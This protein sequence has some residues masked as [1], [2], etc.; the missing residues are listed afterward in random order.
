MTIGAGPD[1]LGAGTRLVT[2]LLCDFANVR[3]GLLNVVSGGITRIICGEGFPARLPAFLAMSVCVEAH[4]VHD[5]HTGRVTL[6]HTDTL[7]EIARMDLEFSGQADL[8]PGEGMNMH[9][10]LPLHGITVERSGQVDISVAINDQPAGLLS[11]WLLDAGA[12]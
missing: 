1:G 3:E 5:R 6:R 11:V 4:R 8:H 7:D 2:L 10:A 12:R 9:L